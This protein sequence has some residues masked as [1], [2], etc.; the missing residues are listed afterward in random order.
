MVRG[1]QHEGT[2]SVISMK[3]ETEAGKDLSGE[4]TY[5]MT[6]GAQWCAIEVGDE[7]V[8]DDMLPEGRNTISF[9]IP[10]SAVSG[11]GRLEIRFIFPD[12]CEPGNGDGR[13]HAAAFEKLRIQD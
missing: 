2:E 12:A 11:D 4:W 3:M 9:D 5:C 6:N 8:F 13:L 1:E 10:A 7:L